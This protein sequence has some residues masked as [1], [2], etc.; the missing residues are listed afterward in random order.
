ML[1]NISRDYKYLYISL[2]HFFFAHEYAL[3]SDLFFNFQSILVDETM[4]IRL[5]NNIS[6]S[7][8]ICKSNLHLVSLL[9]VFIFT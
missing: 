2:V 4:D 1:S 9:L 5:C 6:D 7:L 8:L 3:I